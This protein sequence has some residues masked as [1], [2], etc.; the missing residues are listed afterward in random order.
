MPISAPSACCIRVAPHHVRLCSS[1][2][3]PAETRDRVKDA[4]FPARYCPI[5]SR[6]VHCHRAILRRTRWD[7]ASESVTLPIT[8][9]SGCDPVS[10]LRRK[11]WFIIAETVGRHFFLST[12]EFVIQFVNK[13]SKSGLAVT[14][15]SLCQN[16]RFDLRKNV[17]E[18]AVDQNIVVIQPVADLRL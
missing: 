12:L 15:E 6:S 3:Q 1:C 4:L 10:A 11:V 16:N 8:A 9:A 17:I 7:T 13:A 5:R 2:R 18:I 14:L